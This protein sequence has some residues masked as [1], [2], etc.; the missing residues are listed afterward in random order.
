VNIS[1]DRLDR[2]LCM[3]SAPAGRFGVPRPLQRPAGTAPT[4]PAGHPCQG[5]DP[6]NL[7]P[8]LHPKRSTGT[9]PLASSH[10]LKLTLVH[11]NG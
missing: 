9:E 5:P 3:G 8:V 1:D 2:L 7:M 10:R 6:M 11:P 4:A